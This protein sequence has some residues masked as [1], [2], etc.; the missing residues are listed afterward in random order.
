MKVLD[1]P[2]AIKIELEKGEY[3]FIEGEPLEYVYYLTSG[4][5]CG[6]LIFLDGTEFWADNIPC[7]QGCIS[8]IALGML[9]A[10]ETTYTFSSV[11]L[12]KSICYRI[13]ANL[14]YNYL[15]KHPEELF[16]FTKKLMGLYTSLCKKL[17]SRQ[18]QRT[19]ESYCTFLLEHSNKINNEIVLD[20]SYSN[21]KVSTLLGI[22][23]VTLSRMQ[24]ALQTENI[25]ERNNKGIKIKNPDLLEQCANGM[26][27]INYRKRINKTTE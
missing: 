4:S 6:N 7:D 22:H 16:E 3:L 17:N 11:A 24:T 9:L 23:P 8:V 27:T 2:K 13:P 15:Q 1:F 21:V 26:H 25:I 19:I 18:K 12:E 10:N 20:K 5:V 14:M